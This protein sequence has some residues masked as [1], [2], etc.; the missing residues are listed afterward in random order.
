MKIC[1][2]AKTL[3]LGKM[4]VTRLEGEEGCLTRSPEGAVQ[5]IMR[6]L[7]PQ[8]S[9]ALGE[10]VIWAEDAILMLLVVRKTRPCGPYMTW[11]RDI[12]RR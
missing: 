8:S 6:T 12:A 1:D 10:A 7:F 9:K 11:Q 2:G 5:H 3:K 4:L